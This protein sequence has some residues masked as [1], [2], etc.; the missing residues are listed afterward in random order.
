MNS[1]GKV[2]GVGIQS[3]LGSDFP[4]PIDEAADH[5][6]NSLI[7]LLETDQGFFQFIP[8]MECA[9]YSGPIFDTVQDFIR[10][11]PAIEVSTERRDDHIGGTC[12]IEQLH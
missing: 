7:S 8:A 12:Q 1:E 2:D 3:D 11:Y 4:N 6:R 5:N 10:T 9:V